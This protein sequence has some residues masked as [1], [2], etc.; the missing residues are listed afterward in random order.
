MTDKIR[1]L[2]VDDEPLAREKIRM[3]LSRDAEIEVAGEY[4]DGRSAAEAILEQ[5]PD[6]VFLDVQMPEMDGFE[7]LRAIAGARAPVVVFVTAYDE[8]ALRAFE[9]HA[10][11][12]LLKPFDAQRFT[13]AL[14]AAKHRVRTDRGVA[15]GDRL[16]RLL[17][18]LE[19]ERGERWLK[20]LV[21]KSRGRIF[22]VPVDDIDWIEAAGNYVGLHVGER[23]H[24]IR[25]TMKVLE[26]Q[27]DPAGFVRVHRSYIVNIGRIRQIEPWFNGEYVIT[28]EGGAQI[29]SGGSYRAAL[30][31]LL[32]NPA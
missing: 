28:L 20:R 32:K 19:R 26:E 31:R 4:G 3:L 15:L 5:S 1:V 22:F 2:I 25:A 6:L 30:K 7:T 8:Y 10:L 9:V 14:E 17:G 11:D 27:L 24:L 12:Y 18:A 16:Q 23:E 29:T 13:A 21:V